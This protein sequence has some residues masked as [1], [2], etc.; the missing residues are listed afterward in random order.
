MV[1]SAI[2]VLCG[3]VG[4]Y[5]TAIQIPLSPETHDEKTIAKSSTINRLDSRKRDDDTIMTLGREHKVVT[6]EL[7]DVSKE[8]D[9]FVST[10][11]SV[12]PEF[13]RALRL[14]QTEY[15][16]LGLGIRTVSFLKIQVYVVGIYVA[17]DDISAL[18]NKLIKRINPLATTL[19]VGEKDELKSMLNDPEKSEE[20]WDAILKDGACR[21]LIRIVPTR[22]TDFGHLRDAWVRSMTSRA[23]KVGWND[24]KFGEDVAEFKRI[25]ARGSV[26][27][28]TELILSRGKKGNLK[29]WYHDD[30]PSHNDNG[31]NKLGELWDE[32][33]SRAVWLG[34]LAG[35]GVACEGA[36][37][38]IVASLLKFVE[39][40][41]GAG[42]REI[43]V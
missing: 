32:R 8:R 39:R 35:R 3:M 17:V 6:K 19:V 12:V 22:N 14:D 7:G 26:P 27:K 36:R 5:V 41:S 25:F 31:I 11:N 42:I 30:G 24:E 20:I 18:Q 9:S 16:L 13:P 34:Y 38:G 40:P 4:L 37:E 21:M 29:V 10:G 1:Y 2:G 43:Y 23:Q 15:Q 33:V 28:G